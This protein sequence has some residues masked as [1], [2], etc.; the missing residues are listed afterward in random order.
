MTEAPN[1]GLR[2][3]VDRLQQHLGVP[4]IIPEIVSYQLDEKDNE[5]AGTPKSG[6][7]GLLADKDTNIGIE[8]LVRNEHRVAATIEKIEL[9]IKMPGSAERAYPMENFDSIGT[10]TPVAFGSPQC[11]HVNCT[12]KNTSIRSLVRY[13]FVVRV[14]DGTNSVQESEERILS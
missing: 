4:K 2:R 14:T 8:L 1:E 7:F 11:G 3:E 12:I 10:R 13:P 6:F 5:F 9:I